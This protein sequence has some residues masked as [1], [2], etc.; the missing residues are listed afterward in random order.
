MQTLEE[1]D[2]ECPLS[3]MFCKRLS[4]EEFEE[5][6]V[7]Y[8]DQA[9]RD[10]FRTMDRNPALCEKVIRRRKQDELEKSGFA[11]LIKA[12]FF[13]AVEGQMNHCNEVNGEELRCRLD[14]LKDEM[15]KVQEYA[16]EAKSTATRSSKR[17]AEKRSGA[18]SS[19]RLLA[20]PTVPVAAPPAKQLA[21]KRLIVSAEVH[22]PKSCMVPP[23]VPAAPPLPPPPVPAST[24]K[25]SSPLRDKTNSQQLQMVVPATP[26]LLDSY[27]LSKL[28][29]P[30]QSLVPLGPHPGTGSC[31]RGSL[32]SVQTELLS[33]NPL[34]RLRS[35]G[36]QRSPGGTPVQTPKKPELQSG[37]VASPATAFNTALLDKFRNVG[38]PLEVAREATGD[39]DSD[40]SGFATPQGTP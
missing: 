3:M 17:L 27:G 1:F 28:N 30:F 12:K 14:S 13:R 35:T 29:R 9:L 18:Q 5:Q 25:F 36:V 16:Q 32:T 40:G 2:Q 38:S 37:E 6:A 7:S 8:T 22:S 24:A 26:E 39:S 15:M 11:S 19:R 10:L 20:P 4:E 31:N 21:E 33:G 34:K 23:T